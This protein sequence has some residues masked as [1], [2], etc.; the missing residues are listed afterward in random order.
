LEGTSF[1]R[2]TTH[3]IIPVNVTNS[4]PYIN[5]SQLILSRLLLLF[6]K[7]KSKEE[8]QQKASESNQM[9]QQFNPQ[10]QGYSP[11]RKKFFSSTPPKVLV[12]PCNGGTSK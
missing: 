1:A 8:L 6:Y 11:T 7:E 12:S 5:L 3:P 4:F 10:Q 9:N 2:N